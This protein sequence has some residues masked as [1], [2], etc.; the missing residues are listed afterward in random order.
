MNLNNSSTEER[1]WVL[2]LIEGDH[3]EGV[4][5]HDSLSAGGIPPESG[6]TIII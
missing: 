3:P 6:G 1:E 5:Q 2:R 4:C